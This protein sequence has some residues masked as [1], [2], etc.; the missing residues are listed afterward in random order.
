MGSLNKAVLVS[1]SG[2]EHRIKPTMTALCVS[3][4]PGGD[5]GT[6][7]KEADGGGKKM[8]KEPAW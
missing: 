2:M 8:F 6:A 5:G 1:P 4:F 7:P 3:V